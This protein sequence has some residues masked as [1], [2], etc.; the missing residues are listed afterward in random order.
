IDLTVVGPEDPLAQGIVDVFQR[1]GLRIF[2]PSRDAAQVE[3]SKVFAKRLMRDADVPTAEFRVFDHPDPA[4]HYIR[5]REYVILP[6]GQRLTAP[7]PPDLF[8]T[9][10]GS[11]YPLTP[12]GRPALIS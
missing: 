4:R 9:A 10:G 1:E 12:N 5:S 7:F 6:D 8:V 3:A 2:G 11:K